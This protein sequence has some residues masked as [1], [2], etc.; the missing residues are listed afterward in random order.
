MSWRDVWKH[1]LR[2][3]RTIRVCQPLP[4]F[5]SILSNATL[6]PCRGWLCYYSNGPPGHSNAPVDSFRYFENQI[7]FDDDS[8][9]FGFEDSNGSRGQPARRFTPG[10]NLASPFW[11]VPVKDLLEAAIWFSAFA[12][13]TVE[14]RGRKMK[15]RRDGTMV[16]EK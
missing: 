14:W 6:G 9:L 2:W 16:E 4:Y 7:A 1:Q 13:D 12:G 11:L 5:F 3:A 10:R 15:L 8:R